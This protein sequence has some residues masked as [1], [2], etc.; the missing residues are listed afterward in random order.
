MTDSD[1][2]R[3]GSGPS[4]GWELAAALSVLMVYVVALSLMPRHVFWSPDEG[5][6]LIQS[7]SIS[8][9]LRG[10]SYEVPY[11]GRTIDPAFDF[12]LPKITHPRPAGPSAQASGD[13][14]PRLHGSLLF[15]LISQPGYAAIGA[16]GLYL[17][18]L[19][20]GW[21]SAVV[22]G[23]IAYAIDPR[24]SAAT[25]VTVGLATPVFFYSLTVWEHAPATLCALLAVWAL[26]TGEPGRVRTLVAIV[27]PLAVGA[28]LRIETVAVAAACV[29]T[30]ALVA[31][32]GSPHDDRTSTAVGKG[33]SR[34]KIGW[35]AAVPTAVMLL[36]LFANTITT[37]HFRLISHLPKHLWRG[38]DELPHIPRSLEILFVE[39]DV[40]RSVVSSWFAIGMAAGLALCLVGPFLRRSRLVE[41][42]QIA[43][44]LTVATFSG[45]L[46]LAE[47]KYRWLHSVFVIAPFLAFW[48]YSI[49]EAWRSR[50]KSFTLAVFAVAYLFLGTAAILYAYARPWGLKAGL[51]WGHRYFLPLFPV[52][53]V[54][55]LVA[56]K[57]YWHA[58]LTS[59]SCAAFWAV[60]SLSLTVGAIY[61]YRGVTQMR[62]DRQAMAKWSDVVE[63][64]EYVV[65]DLWWLPSVVAP[66]Y[67]RQ[68]IFFT[69]RRRA[70]ADW[71]DLATPH[72]MSRFA[73]ATIGPIEEGTSLGRDDLRVVGGGSKIHAGLRLIVFDVGTGA[74][75]R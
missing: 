47:T 49:P 34:I 24:L 40:G 69:P 68:P 60:L 55:T 73:F 57:A 11:P 35:Y 13:V 59:A 75:G 26:L 44:F 62:D 4:R 12:F 37:R 64:N 48:A 52:L 72:G 67:L 22:S 17:F 74:D 46:A 61:Q 29:V 28:M 63:Q 3:R 10:L 25:V 21:L 5:A 30:W 71:V 1:S 51:E 8:L 32:M 9:S 14:R 53:T 50:T 70:V 42:V 6:K 27:T 20:C 19:L 36:V 39:A 43:A 65:T 7:Q 41:W 54:L 15:S 56:A 33:S 38:L 58:T 18:P 45:A 23:R 66:V 16:T 2:R 31:F